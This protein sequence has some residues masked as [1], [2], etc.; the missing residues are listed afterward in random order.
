[1][2]AEAVVAAA[3]AAIVAAGHATTPSVTL[4]NTADPGVVMPAAGLGTGCAIG[5]CKI[6]P[7]SDMVAYNMSLTWLG[8]GGRRIDGAD[9]YGCEPGIGL[10]IKHSGLA[11]EDVFIVSKTGP[12]GLAWPLGYNETLQQ[13]KE[14]VANYS[15]TYVDLLLIHWPTNYGPCSYHG[16]KPS[17]PTTDPECDTALPTYSEKGCRLSTW[18]AMLCGSRVWQRQWVC[19]TSTRRI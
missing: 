15:T 5:G 12:G 7:G 13:A 18:R 8:M 19:Q 16:P 4:R 2:R 11:R 14:I 6:S 10:A 3:L 1:M 9:S 17:I